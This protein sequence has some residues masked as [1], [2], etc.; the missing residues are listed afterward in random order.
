MI[1]A[2]SCKAREF[3][4]RVFSI[5][6]PGYSIFIIG[7]EKEEKEVRIQRKISLAPRKILL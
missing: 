6:S 7:Y 3:K 2:S 1:T 5:K 4:V